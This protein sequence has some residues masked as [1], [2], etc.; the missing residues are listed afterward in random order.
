MSLLD[1]FI[2]KHGDQLKER[3]NLRSDDELRGRLLCI[4][5]EA[6]ALHEDAELQDTPHEDAVIIQRQ[7]VNYDLAA[8][9][10]EA[11]QHLEHKIAAVTNGLPGNKEAAILRVDKEELLKETVEIVLALRNLDFLRRAVMQGWVSVF[12]RVFKVPLTDWNLKYRV[13]RALGEI[14]DEIIRE[15][16]SGE[17]VDF[18]AASAG[19]LKK[20]KTLLTRFGFNEQG[21]LVEVS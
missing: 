10:L 20:R 21:G 9:V 1:A 12:T 19:I 14:I 4:C 17:G 13:G 7:A 16:E 8:A 15:T 5:L 2:A 18:R 3:L 6:I 11:M